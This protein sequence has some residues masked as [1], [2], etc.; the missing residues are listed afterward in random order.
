MY[1]IADDLGTVGPTSL[2]LQL[3]FCMSGRDRFHAA[4]SDKK[5]TPR[6]VVQ[7]ADLNHRMIIGGGL[8]ELTIANVHRGMIDV[9]F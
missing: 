1:S 5:S 2:P 6:L 3:G 7:A 9:F 8:N 4:A